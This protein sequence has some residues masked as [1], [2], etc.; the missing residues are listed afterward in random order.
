MV[1]GSR[2]PSANDRSPSRGH[3]PASGAGRNASYAP[4]VPSG[5]RESHRPPPTPGVPTPFNDSDTARQID[6]FFP[7]AVTLESPRLLD[8]GDTGDY[9]PIHPNPV[10]TD[11]S[12]HSRFFGR[13]HSDGL[14]ADGHETPMSYGSF[15][16]GSPAG[17]EA[18][19]PPSLVDGTDRQGLLGATIWGV[20]RKLQRRG[21]KDWFAEP[22]GGRQ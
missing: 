2:P 21:T 20:R 14:D 17:S 15:G 5:L 13:E 22:R 18:N 16:P 19:Y 8:P 6:Y 10:D 11:Q 12:P 3:S 7:H 1:S 4:A 9:S